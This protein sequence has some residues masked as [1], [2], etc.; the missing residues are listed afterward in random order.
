MKDYQT[1]QRKALLDF[2]AQNSTEAFSADQIV[3]LLGTEKVSRSAVYRNIDRML[4]EGLLRKSQSPDGRKAL[5]QY[6]DCRQDCNRIHLQ[7]GK[8]GRIFHME[9]ASDEERLKS[10]LD[11]SGFH[12]DEQAT[13]LHGTCRS[14]HLASGEAKEGRHGH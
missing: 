9:N 13:M 6:V 8:C 12:L 14:C 7:C 5:Y 2:F 11:S 10:V 3:S 1:G 4:Q